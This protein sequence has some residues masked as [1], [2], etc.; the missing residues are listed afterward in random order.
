MTMDV[1]LGRTDLSQGIGNAS[2]I[3]SVGVYMGGWWV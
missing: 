1:Q 3:V 2:R